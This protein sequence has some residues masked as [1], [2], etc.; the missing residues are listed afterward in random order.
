MKKVIIILIV[1]S[2][3]FTSFFIFKKEKKENKNISVSIYNLIGTY[4]WHYR[5][6]MYNSRYA[7]GVFA[8]NGGTGYAAQTESSRFV[9]TN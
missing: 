2:L 8:L 4:P 3:I 6:G 7:P 9:I 1:F 5:G